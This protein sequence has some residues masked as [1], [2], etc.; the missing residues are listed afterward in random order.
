MKRALFVAKFLFFLISV[1]LIA[2]NTFLWYN[3]Y[4][5]GSEVLLG[6]YS[7]TVFALSQSLPFLTIAIL[8]AWRSETWLAFILGVFAA[9]VLFV[10]MLIYY[11]FSAHT[12]FDDFWGAQAIVGTIVAVFL[13]GIAERLS[14]AWSDE[15]A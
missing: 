4:S 11:I 5:Q 13:F 6:L 9:L 8:I 15:D 1:L 7:R 12:I 14:V 10:L 3:A 2:G